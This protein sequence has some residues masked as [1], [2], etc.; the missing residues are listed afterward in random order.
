[1]IK[2]ILILTLISSCFF[3]KIQSAK[4]KAEIL[5][6]SDAACKK[7]FYDNADDFDKTYPK[8]KDFAQA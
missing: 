2:S 3:Q 6:E 5:S 1:M 8:P 7:Y 4:T